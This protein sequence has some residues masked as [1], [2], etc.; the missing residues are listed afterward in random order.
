MDDDCNLIGERGRRLMH[1]VGERGA[2]RKHLPSV[3]ASRSSSCSSFSNSASSFGSGIIMPP[4]PSLGLD[5]DC[6]ALADGL[7]NPSTDRIRKGCRR[8]PDSTLLSL[9][10]LAFLE[11]SLFPPPFSSF[12]SSSRPLLSSSS[13]DADANDSSVDGDCLPMEHNM[14]D[15]CCASSSSNE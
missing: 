13:D 1:S 5:D 3:V 2:A 4:C 11:P 9:D 6:L 12:G 8:R 7:D 14:E 10:D 15:G